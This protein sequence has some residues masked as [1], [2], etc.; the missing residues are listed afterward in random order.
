MFRFNKRVRED[1]IR[2]FNR[3]AWVGGFTNLSLASANAIAH[4]NYAGFLVAGG[5]ILIGKAIAWI[6]MSYDP[7][8]EDR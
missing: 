7:S 3:I 2:T 4:G 1:M 8:K 6:L 5:F